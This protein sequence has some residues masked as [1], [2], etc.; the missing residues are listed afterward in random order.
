MAAATLRR[1]SPRARASI[2]GAGL[3]LPAMAIVVIFQI[4]PLARGA[5]LSL[6]SPAANGLTAHNYER[7]RRTTRPGAPRSSTPARSCS[8]VPVFVAVPLLLAFALFQNFQAA[9]SSSAR[10]SSCPG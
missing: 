2:G 4:Y 10:R 1:R 7:M 5:V 3:M 9:G 6:H 8:T